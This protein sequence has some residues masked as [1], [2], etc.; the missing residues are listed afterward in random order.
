[1]EVWCLL[2][3][4]YLVDWEGYGPEERSWIP[5]RFIMDFRLISD[6]HQSHPDQPAPPSRPPVT[7]GRENVTTRRISHQSESDFSSSPPF[8]LSD[9]QQK[10]WLIGAKEYC[11]SDVYTYGIKQTLSSKATFNS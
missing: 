10:D 2:G 3:V 7:S 9:P 1:M 6:F 11:C 5:A 8:S 4:Q